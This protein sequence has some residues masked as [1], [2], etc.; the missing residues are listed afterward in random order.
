M[1]H[2]P[3]LTILLFLSGTV[4]AQVVECDTMGVAYDAAHIQFKRA[5]LVT[6]DSSI[7]IPMVNNTHTN[8]AYPQIKLEN[9]TPLPPGMS[10]YNTGWNVFASAWNVG[11]KMPVNVDYYVNTTIPDNYMVTFKLYVTNFAPLTIDS[12]VF[13]NTLTINLKPVIPAAVQQIN[14]GITG[15]SFYPNPVTNAIYLTQ[16]AAG[17]VIEIYSVTGA[18]VQ[19]AAI[20]QY[21]KLDVS[22]LSTGLYFIKQKG[23]ASMQKLLKL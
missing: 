23:A 4:A 3:L 19:A 22:S 17:A 18:L 12:C 1:K 9:T 13:V 6:P 10:L 8:F 7:I 2:F 21:N 5:I 11:D 15:L 16:V 20:D 14:G